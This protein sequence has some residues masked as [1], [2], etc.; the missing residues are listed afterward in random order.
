M[1][2]IHLTPNRSVFGNSLYLKIFCYKE[3]RFPL[4]YIYM[5]YGSSDTKSAQTKQTESI[6]SVTEG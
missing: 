4:D 1:L 5:G 2:N 6:C 3:N